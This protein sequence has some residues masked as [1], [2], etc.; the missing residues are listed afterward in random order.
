MILQKSIS[1]CFKAKKQLLLFP[2]DHQTEKVSLYSTKEVTIKEFHCI[3]FDSQLLQVLDVLVFLFQVSTLTSPIMFKQEL[4]TTE[5]SISTSNIPPNSASIFVSTII[6]PPGEQASTPQEAFSTPKLRLASG[7]ST[8]FLSLYPS[9][10]PHSLNF[11]LS[12]NLSYPDIFTL[13]LSVLTSHL[14]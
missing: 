7:G 2:K 11:R 8:S 14:D 5:I 10:Q 9:R 13:S 4:T 6:G 1:L 3:I 12:I